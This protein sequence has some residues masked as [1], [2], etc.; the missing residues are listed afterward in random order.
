[1]PQS[2]LDAG[3]H[4]PKRQAFAKKVVHAPVK[5]EKCETCHQRH[6]LVGAMIPTKPALRCAMP[7][8]RPSK[9]ISSG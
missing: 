6:G 1:L 8:M 3:C 2:C 5:E 9:R 7:A 4:E